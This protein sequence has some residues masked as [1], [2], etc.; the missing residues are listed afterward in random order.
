MG[1]AE[2]RLAGG[3]GACLRERPARETRARARA[4]A[5]GVGVSSSLPHL[6]PLPAAA[7]VTVVAAGRLRNAA[8]IKCQAAFPVRHA[9]ASGSL[10]A[11]FCG[12]A[13]T[14]GRQQIDTIKLVDWLTAR[15]LTYA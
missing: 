6:R 8:I 2:W 3:A 13:H 4:H 9:N 5:N 11:A 1:P 14:L 12:R 7:L 10:R 15:L